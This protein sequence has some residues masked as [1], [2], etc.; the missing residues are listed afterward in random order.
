[1]ATLYY[2]DVEAGAEIPAISKTP[3]TSQ[4][5]RWAGA[6]GDFYPI[7]YD[8]DAAQGVG[9]PNVI[10][11][12]QLKGQF[13]I[14]MLTDWIGPLG[15]VRQFNCRYTGMDFPGVALSCSGSITRK[16][17]DGDEYCLECEMAL[18]NQQGETTVTATAIVTLP[19]R[20]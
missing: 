11:H 8:K 18:Q 1:M 19:A 10:V 5:V 15:I 4:L 3:T 7:H 2:D 20:A 6:S 17:T 13:L 9:L 12:G 14:Q 16:F